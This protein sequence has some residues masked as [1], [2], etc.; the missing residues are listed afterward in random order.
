MRDTDDAQI[1]VDISPIIPRVSGYVKAIHVNDNDTVD[2][3]AVLVTLD[4]SDLALKV[5]SAE[6]AVANAEAAVKTTEASATAAHANEAN[7]E[8]DRTK[9]AEDLAR[10]QGLLAGGAMTK[11]EFDAANAAAESAGEQ[12]KSTTDQAGAAESQIVSAEAQVKSKQ[13]DLDNAKLQL[14]YATIL[15]LSREQLQK[16]MWSLAS[17]SSPA[18][19]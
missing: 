7:A 19:H 10:D 12:V 4:A 8:V 9:T 15:P 6:A 1:D 2:S 5:S 3:N 11:E 13:V 14:S 18:S 16:G 17:I